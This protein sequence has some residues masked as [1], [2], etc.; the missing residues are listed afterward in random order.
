M[1]LEQLGQKPSDVSDYQQVFDLPKPRPDG[2]LTLAS[3]DQQALTRAL[4][5]ARGG[6]PLSDEQITRLLQMLDP[7]DKTLVDTPR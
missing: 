3:S 2:R 5:E 1:A 6:K 4:V 7:D